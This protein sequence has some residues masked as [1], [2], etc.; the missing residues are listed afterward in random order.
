MNL[1]RLTVITVISVA[2]AI[3][4]VVAFSVATWVLGANPSL[5]AYIVIAFAAYAGTALLLALNYVAGDGD[6]GL[7]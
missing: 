1:E 4:W 2:V 5:T 7:D 3:F 6:A